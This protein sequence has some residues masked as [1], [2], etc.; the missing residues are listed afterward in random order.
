MCKE[1][2]LPKL[3]LPLYSVLIV[4]AMFMVIVAFTCHK[5]GLVKCTHVITQANNESMRTN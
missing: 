5:M 1:N 3:G 4:G 2:E